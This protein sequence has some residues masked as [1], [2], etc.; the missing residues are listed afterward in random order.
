[1]SSNDSSQGGHGLNGGRGGEGALGKSTTSG[2]VYAAEQLD[3]AKESRRIGQRD[4]GDVGNGRE[5][6]CSCSC[7][8]STAPNA[9]SPDSAFNTPV[10]SAASSE[11]HKSLSATHGALSESG[12]S[13][14][15]QPDL[16]SAS[17]LIRNLNNTYE[18]SNNHPHAST[19]FNAGSSSLIDT[20]MDMD[21]DEPSTST[22][23]VT[24]PY[25]TSTSTTPQAS[26]PNEMVLGHLHPS[27]SSAATPANT[28]FSSPSNRV[29]GPIT[30]F[31]D[32][33]LTALHKPKKGLAAS[34]WALQNEGK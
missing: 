2:H 29:P 19:S 14:D 26:P 28:A 15:N 3:V 17:V 33:E 20:L 21:I 4:H 10:G 11:A 5:K 22:S 13:P 9:A 8:V 34:R 16:S 31:R 7:I 12:W 32:D 30:M 27:I 6:T 24:P 25:P 1:M 18:S 23:Q